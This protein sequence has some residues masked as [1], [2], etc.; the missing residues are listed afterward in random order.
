VWEGDEDDVGLRAGAEK[1]GSE[2]V[3]GQESVKLG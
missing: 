3:Q 2:Q 1:G